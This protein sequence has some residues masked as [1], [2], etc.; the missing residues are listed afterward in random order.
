VTRETKFFWADIVRTIWCL[1]SVKNAEQAAR[2]NGGGLSVPNWSTS[3]TR[4]RWQ[5]KDQSARVAVGKQ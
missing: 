1:Y 2:G 3:V 5:T 4:S